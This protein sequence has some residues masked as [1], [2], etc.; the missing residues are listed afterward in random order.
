[1]C[2]YSTDAYTIMI[3]NIKIIIGIIINKNNYPETCCF[4][5]NI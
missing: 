4:E 3:Q 1:M 2:W 5:N